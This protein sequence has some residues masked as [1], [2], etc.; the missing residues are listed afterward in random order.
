MMLNHFLNQ[1]YRTPLHIAADN[2]YLEMIKLLLKNGAD[3]NA[4][5][6]DGNKPLDLCINDETY[7]LLSECAIEEDDISSECVLPSLSPSP[8]TS[9]SP[10]PIA[11]R[12]KITIPS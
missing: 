2:G 12:A 1:L 8:S 6:S 5:D 4:E 10:R 3:A 9:Q 7:E 11:K